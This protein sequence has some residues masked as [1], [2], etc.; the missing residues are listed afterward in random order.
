L[1]N[2]WAEKISAGLKRQRKVYTSLGLTTLQRRY[3]DKRRSGAKHFR[4][5]VMK[6]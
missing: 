5:R 2:S 3:G 6:R 1:R 4:T